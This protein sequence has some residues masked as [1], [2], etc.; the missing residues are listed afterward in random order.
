MKDPDLRKLLKKEG[1]DI[2]GDRKTLINR[3]QRFT[4]LWN[5]QCDSD[6]PM[7]RMQIINKVRREEQNLSEAAVT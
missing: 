5:S 7:T 1:L 2:Q 4:I 3:H 6:N